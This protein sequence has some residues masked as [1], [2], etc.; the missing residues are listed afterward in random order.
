MYKVGCGFFGFLA[1]ISA[2]WIVFGVL[3]SSA[4]INN[5]PAPA[6]TSQYISKA[7]AQNIAVA[8]AG[9]AGGIGLS[10]VLC[11]G[12]PSLLFF[13]LLALLCYSAYR[14]AEDRAMLLQ[15]H[16]VNLATQQQRNE[17]LQGM[18]MTQL[19]QAQMQANQIRQQFQPSAQARLPEPPPTDSNA[20]PMLRKG[21]WATRARKI[22]SSND[23]QPG[24]TTDGSISKIDHWKGGDRP[25][26]DRPDALKHYFPRKEE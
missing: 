20:G 7:D 24:Q 3:A 9:I 16:A 6:P 26:D 5:P 4:A 15:M 21:Q 10:V 17:I 23:E 19:A 8:S 12:G 13:G 11:T 1:L 22:K 18:A 2:L 14:A 25:W